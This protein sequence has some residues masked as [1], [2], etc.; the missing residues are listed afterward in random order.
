MTC[1]WQV[2]EVGIPEV[3][4]RDTA[5]PLHH[6]GI[7]AGSQTIEGL[8]NLPPEIYVGGTTTPVIIGTLTADGLTIEHHL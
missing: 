8:T 7:I 1:H 3:N 5:S 6:D 2:H 4:L